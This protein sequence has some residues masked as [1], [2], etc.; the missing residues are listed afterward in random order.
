VLGEH[1]A[2]VKEMLGTF[3]VQLKPS[4]FRK[5]VKPLLKEACT[6][7]FGTATGLVDMMVKHF[8]S[9]KAGSATKAWP[10]LFQLPCLFV[11]GVLVLSS[12]C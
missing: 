8:P 9:S 7:I 12:R 6:R 2:G 11:S 3:G 5:D 4:A 1:D 10:P